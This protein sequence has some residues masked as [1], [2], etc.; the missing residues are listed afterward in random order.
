MKKT[1]AAFS[2][3]CITFS[4][5]AL[6]AQTPAGI[7]AFPA[8]SQALERIGVVAAA[9]GKV[10]LKMPGQVGRIAQSGQTIFM[11]DEVTTDVRGHL[12]ILLL[13]ET[14][15]T[16]GP[17]TA[18]IIDKFVYDPKSQ[19]GEIRA[20]ITKGI[21]RYVSGKIAA[22]RPN[23]V[24]LKLP[25]ATIG[26]RGTIVAGSVGREGQGMAVL[27]GPGDNNDSGDRTGSFTIE[28]KSGSRA[29]VNRTGFGVE[30]RTHGELSGVFKFSTD[31][32]GVLTQGLTPS[33]QGQG[34]AP[35]EQGQGGE[36]RGPGPGP[37][38]QSLFMGG[39][40]MEGLSGEGRG[41]AI[42]TGRWMNLFG[43]MMDKI[44]DQSNVVAQDI[45]NSPIH[46]T[47]TK[48][49]ELMRLVSGIYHYTVSGDLLS[50]SGNDVGNLSASWDLV[51]SRSRVMM[52]GGSN[53][54][55]TVF[56]AAGN[57]VEKVTINAQDLT[58]KIDAVMHQ[59]VTG[60]GFKSID[61]TL[62]NVNGVIG[63]QGT[64]NVLYDNNGT[65]NDTHGEASGPRSP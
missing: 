12:Q 10:E 43:M 57:P 61:I 16:I 38:A 15:F 18:I 4:L 26:F 5:P 36:S 20:S 19:N 65:L 46:E 60:Q 58:S 25:A 17:N 54:S 23:N 21:F 47:V 13:D 44:D 34:P 41:K 55:V 22:K 45:T 9:R 53:S 27:L 3:F 40:N 64:L 24:S 37:H 35:H 32:L 2:V 56:N 8:V 6:F 59:G 1:I 31:Q 51:I 33:Q 52:G 63:R 30:M 11:G 49:A 48:T 14:V 62:N 50:P 7:P 28:G 39:E 29:E 42:Q